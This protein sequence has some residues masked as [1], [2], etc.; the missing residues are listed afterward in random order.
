MLHGLVGWNVFD[1]AEPG[2]RAGV[3]APELRCGQARAEPV[4]PAAG[5]PPPR[6]GVATVVDELLP[7]AVG[8][9]NPADPERRHVDDVGGT[10]VVQRIRFIRGVHAQHEGA[11]GH[12]HRRS[13][14]SRPARWQVGGLAQ[15]RRAGAQVQR[16]QDG[17]VVLVFVTD[18]HAVHEGRAVT[19]GVVGQRVQR[20]QRGGTHCAAI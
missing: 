2:A 9:R 3:G 17:F 12:Q 14:D 18:H 5:R 20:I 13:G 19:G 4:L 11:A 1:V 16:L 6:L 10:L 15:Q 8:D 7:F